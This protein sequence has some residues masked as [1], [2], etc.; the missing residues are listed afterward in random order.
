MS[1]AFA[2]TLMVADTGP[3]TGAVRLTVGA[4]VSLLTVTTTPADVVVLPAA[5][6]AL[7]VNVC[8]PF[9]AVVVFQDIL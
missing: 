5:S 7:A 3:A 1:A 2:S 8:V 6:R 4:C 9:V